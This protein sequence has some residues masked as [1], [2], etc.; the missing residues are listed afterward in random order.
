MVELDL[1][2]F[3]A[4]SNSNRVVILAKLL[5]R[6]RRVTELSREL[7]LSPPLV[8]INL[9][10]LMRAGLVREGQGV[11]SKRHRSPPLIEAY[12][13]AVEFRLEVTPQ[14]VKRLAEEVE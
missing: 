3:K 8:H 14:A 1:E 2:V 4:L 9:K 12:Y 6:P 11:V 13:E 7:G 5:E 10:K